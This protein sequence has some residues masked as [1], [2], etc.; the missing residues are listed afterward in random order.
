MNLVEVFAVPRF[1]VSYKT[2]WNLAS[3]RDA[4]R[5]ILPKLL[6]GC[7]GLSRVFHLD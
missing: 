4:A 1:V 3:S 7:S 5:P 2:V 6:Q